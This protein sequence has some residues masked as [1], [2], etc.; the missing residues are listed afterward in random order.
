MAGLSGAA[1]HGSSSRGHLAPGRSR[2]EQTA[3]VVVGGLVVVVRGLPGGRVTAGQVVAGRVLGGMEAA[4]VI[5]L[6]RFAVKVV[7]RERLVRVVVSRGR[8]GRGRAAGRA[9]RL[10]RDGSRNLVGD[11]EVSPDSSLVSSLGRGRVDLRGSHGARL[12]DD[13]GW[14]PLIAITLR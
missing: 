7:C 9:S 10:E 12:G 5:L 6:D 1:G 14:V 11:R 13:S 2:L 4:A 8:V 3:A